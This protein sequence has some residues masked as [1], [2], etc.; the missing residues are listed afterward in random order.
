MILN[1]WDAHTTLYLYTVC[2]KKSAFYLCKFCL[3][4]VRMRNTHAV[5]FY[6][7]I[8]SAASRFLETFPQGDG[9]RRRASLSPYPHSTPLLVQSLPIYQHLFHACILLYP[10]LSS[11]SR[12][13]YP[14]RTFNFTHLHFLHKLFTLFF[15]SR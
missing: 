4:P 12:P 9:H 11:Y 7:S 5:L 8:V 13:S 2:I 15:L 10:I 14:P 1:R 3:I 6:Y